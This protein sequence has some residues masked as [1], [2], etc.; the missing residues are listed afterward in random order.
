[1]NRILALI[2][3]IAFIGCSKKTGKTTTIE[4]NTNN[5]QMTEVNLFETLTYEDRISVTL[6]EDDP[7][8]FVSQHADYDMKSL[9]R[10][11][12]SQFTYSFQFD[13]NKISLDE[14]M[15]LCENDKSVVSANKITYSSKKKK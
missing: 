4:A 10:M 15:K 3:I 5:S 2:T 13:S 11:S 14:L 1:M 6:K 9:F 8:S 7:K 12:R